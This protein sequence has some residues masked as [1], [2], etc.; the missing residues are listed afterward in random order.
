MA[1]LAS[2]SASEAVGI[3]E[4]AALAGVGRRAAEAGMGVEDRQQRQADAGLG[5][6]AAMRAAI[7]PRS[8]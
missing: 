7:S 1:R 8:A 2:S 3:V 5:A 4:E 6:A